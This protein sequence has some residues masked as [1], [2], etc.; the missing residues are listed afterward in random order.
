MSVSKEQEAQIR[1]LLEQQL[2]CREIANQLGVGI[3]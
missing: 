2:S 1:T 3:M